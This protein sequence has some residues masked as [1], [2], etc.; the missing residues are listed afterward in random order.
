MLVPPLLHM[1]LLKVLKAISGNTSGTVFNHLRASRH[2]ILSLLAHR[3]KEINRPTVNRESLGL[4]IEMYAYLDAC[5]TFTPHGLD[6]ERTMPQ[7][8]FIASVVDLESFPTFGVLFAGSHELYQMVP[9]VSLLA[10]RRL[11][12]EDL[13]YNEPSAALRTMH[14]KIHSRLASWKMPAAAWADE[15]VD[16]Y[17]LRRQAAEALRHALH[18]YLATAI[19]GATVTDQGVRAYVSQ[20]VRAVFAATTSL[21][22]ARRYVATMLWPVLIAGSCMSSTAGQQLLLSELRGGWFQMRQLE[23]MGQLLSLLWQD[24]DPRAYGPY[25]LYVTMK[26]HRLNIANA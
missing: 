15:T 21:V 4:T 23:M 14:D 22:A 19:A 12:E 1:A 25:G 16:D 2:L 13:G 20:H 8:G 5:N 11:A 9:S 7:D 18:I 10:S 17:D 3:S 6:S 24:P 26:K